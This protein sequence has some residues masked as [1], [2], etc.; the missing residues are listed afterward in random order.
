MILQFKKLPLMSFAVGSLFGWIATGEGSSSADQIYNSL[1]SGQRKTE[2]Q[3]KRSR[4][5]TAVMGVRGL[6]TDSE[7][8]NKSLANSNLKAVYEMED[9][10]PNQ[11]M[12]SKIK[13][14]IAS[15]L[16]TK[17]G[18]KTIQPIK[19]DSASVDEL[20]NE[21]DLGRKM[22]A[23]ILGSTR[24]MKSRKIQDYVNSLTTVL[25]QAGLASGR[26]F[27]VAVLDSDQVN[28]FACPGGYIFVTRG[29]LQATRSESQLSA[30][31]GHEIAHVSKRHLLASLQKKISQNKN[32]KKDAAQEN[33][34][35]VSRRRIKPS[36][37]AENSSISQLLGP[38]GVGLTLLQASSEAIDTLLSKGLERQFEL[39]ADTL[40]SQI[41]AAAGFNSASLIE[42][43]QTMKDNQDK[44]KDASATTHPPYTVRIDNLVQF[45]GSLAKTEGTQFS[46]TSLYI[47]V[48]KE[49][50]R[51]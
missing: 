36:Q 27:R 39:E 11:E 17:A 40:G 46:G 32:D 7:R 31:L 13:N 42:L 24:P 48:Q 15:T 37:E 25:A 6:D 16:S 22:A 33:P 10:A 14:E 35:L 43:L 49:L 2:S 29:A 9:R 28:A 50:Q 19:N 20:K 23:Q 18:I 8:G 45:I 12:V 26:P 41:S 3:Q 51:R 47:D 34:N 21:I 30:L 44:K 38:K 4:S 5:S 1:F